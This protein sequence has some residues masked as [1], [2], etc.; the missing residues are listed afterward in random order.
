MVEPLEGVRLSVRINGVQSGVH[1]VSAYRCNQWH[2]FTLIAPIGSQ[3]PK[4]AGLN[5]ADEGA[6]LP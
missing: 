4:I 2:I 5:L 6:M 3:A 1:G